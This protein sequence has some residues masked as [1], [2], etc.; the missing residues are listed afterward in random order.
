MTHETF[1]QTPREAATW[2][3]IQAGATDGNQSS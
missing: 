2:D 3:S 1:T